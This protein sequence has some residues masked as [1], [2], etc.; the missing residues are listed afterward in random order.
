MNVKKIL[1]PILLI[2]SLV[3]VACGGADLDESVSYADSS[4]M[5]FLKGDDMDDADIVCYQSNAVADSELEVIT[6]ISGDRIRIEYMMI[7]PIQGQGDLT[8]V[9]D[10]AYMYMWGDSF[11]GGMMSGFKVAIGSE[12]MDMSDNEMASFVDF[13]TPMLDCST[14]DVDPSYFEIPEDVDFMDMDN[15]EETIMEDFDIGGV[16]LDCSICDQ[17]PASERPSCLE[18]MGCE[19]EE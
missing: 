19:T 8:I 11:L 7:P 12:S 3:F 14:W 10:G 18:A 2:A 9:S 5:D 15:L 1:L 4:L 16:G 6:Y 13:D 17:M